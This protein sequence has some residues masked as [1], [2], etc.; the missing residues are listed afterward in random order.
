MYTNVRMVLISISIMSV[1]I[2]PGHI[3]IFH[4]IECA[5]V[6]VCMYICLHMYAYVCVDTVKH[7]LYVLWGR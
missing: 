4:R 5:R 7:H 3:I 2:T 6:Y 1:I